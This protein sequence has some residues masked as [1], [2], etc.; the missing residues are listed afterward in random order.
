MS[1]CEAFLQNLYR[2]K[3]IH[4][5]HRHKHVICKL[6]LTSAFFGLG[7]FTQTGAIFSMFLYVVPMIAL[8]HDIYIIGEHIKVQRV[9]VFILCFAGL[10][11]GPVCP[12]EIVWE[13]FLA[14]YRE[15][16]SYKAS[17][18]YSGLISSFSAIAIYLTDKNLVL[19]VYRTWIAL[20]VVF[21]LLVLL[22][23]AQMELKIGRI[24]G[25]DNNTTIT[26]LKS[27]YRGED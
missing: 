3:E 2:E 19:G 25:R 17:L 24:G 15:T 10:Q 22:R 8:V 26:E 7:N 12:E 6:T 16:W 23:A 11:N 14:G 18:L 13:K 4:K 5:E 20:W 1:R 27:L 21:M 9:G